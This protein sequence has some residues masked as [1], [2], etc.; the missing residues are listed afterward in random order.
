MLFIP[1]GVFFFEQGCIIAEEVVCYG[2]F[3]STDLASEKVWLNPALFI[4]FV[5]EDVE[6]EP[7]IP[8]QPPPALT[9]SAHCLFSCSP[10]HLIPGGLWTSM[11][12]SKAFEILS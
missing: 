6:L 12:M 1:A 10:E 3:L 9:H 11:Y 5:E 8:A 2:C 4:V 7:T